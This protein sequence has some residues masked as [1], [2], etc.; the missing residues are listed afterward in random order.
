[1]GQKSTLNLNSFINDSFHQT[2]KNI[3]FKNNNSEKINL[4]KKQLINNEIAN[5]NGLVSLG[6]DGLKIISDYVNTNFS[7]IQTQ[8]YS[9]NTNTL[10]NNITLGNLSLHSNNNLNSTSQ[11]KRGVKFTDGTNFNKKS[12]N[13]TNNLNITKTNSVSDNAQYKLKE[14]R[15]SR[16]NI[17]DEGFSIIANCFDKTGSIQ[18]INLKGNKLKD[19]SFKNIIHII[20]SNKS[21]K[22]LVLSHNLFSQHKKENIKMNLKLLNPALKLEI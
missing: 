18:I 8:N 19:K 21:L 7:F 2:N 1:M 20:K 3:K 10:S 4:V 5:F 11:A 6:D 13:I 17:T 15:L 9:T 12:N 14:I 16:C 22:H